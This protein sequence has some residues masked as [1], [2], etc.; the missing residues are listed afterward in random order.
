MK[1]EF[2]KL[3]ECEPLIRKTLEKGGTFKFYPRGTSMEP[4]I[5]AGRDMVVLSP[6]PDCLRKY[7]IVLYKRTNGAFVLH[8]IIKVKGSCCTMRGDNQFVSE[9]GIQKEQMIGMVTQIICNG[10]V[11]PVNDTRHRIAA[12]LWVKT[13]LPR[14][15]WRHFFSCR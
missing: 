3:D 5:H 15:V 6:L 8:R 12:A 1:K 9:P 10:D 2:F 11:I 7:Q 4:T 13:A 14:R